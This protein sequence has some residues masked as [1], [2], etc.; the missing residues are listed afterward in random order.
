MPMARLRVLDN[1]FQA[2]V[3]TEALTADNIPF[4][5]R[6]YTDTAY[7][8]LFVTQKGYASLFVDEEHLER[9]RELDRQLASTVEATGCDTAGLAARI[10]NTLLDAKATPDELDRF[11]DQCLAAGVVGACVSPW[12][13]ERAA[14]RLAGS[15][16]M[17]V[18]VVGFPLGTQT[19]RAK[20]QEALELAHAGAAELDMVLNRGLV[21]AGRLA[22]AVAEVDEVCR[23]AAPAAV[24]VILEVSELGPESAAAVAEAL[25]ASRAAFLKTGTGFF[26]PATPADVALL[27]EACGGAL[28][29]KAAGGIRT[30]DQAVELLEAGAD[31]LGTSAG[32]A[33]LAE[34]AARWPDCREV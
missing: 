16:V 2:D 29:V 24:K 10:E 25:A 5:L 14:A 30:L 33:I 6:T 1:R 4:L 31:R 34:A 28:G 7:D 32:A 22:V 17:V 3:W 15:P 19:R 11:L 23:A 20:V 12:M 13:V 21:L 18:G 9:A 26:G 8:G 27:K